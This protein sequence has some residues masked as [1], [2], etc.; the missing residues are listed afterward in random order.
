VLEGTSY[1][2]SITSRLL[3]SLDLAQLA[4]FVRDDES[5]SKLVKSFRAAIAG[6][7]ALK[8]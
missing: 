3:P 5:Q 4:S 7:R 2:E 1:R 6:G 8:T